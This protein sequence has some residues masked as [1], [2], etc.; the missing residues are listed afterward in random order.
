MAIVNKVNKRVKMGKDDV[1]KYF[2]LLNRIG[3]TR[4]N[5]RKKIERGEGDPGIERDEKD[6]RTL[7]LVGIVENNNLYDLIIETQLI[8]NELITVKTNIKIEKIK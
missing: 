2:D 8:H 3:S 6:R 7:I 4:G 5:K 1:I